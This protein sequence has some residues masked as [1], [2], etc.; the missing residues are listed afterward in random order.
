MP[1]VRWRYS[2][3]LPNTFIPVQQP[4]GII[5]EAGATGLT[6]LSTGGEDVIN[7]NNNFYGI[8]PRFISLDYRITHNLFAKPYWLPTLVL[9]DGSKTYI[10]FPETVLQREMPTIFEN[11]RNIINYRVIGNL[12]VIDKLIENISI[13]IGKSD[14][15]ITKRR[16]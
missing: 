15:A 7:N 14:I 16:R 11:R 8:D 5:P 6:G 9:D 4:R 2:P 12:I 3:P 10:V 1:I 13:R